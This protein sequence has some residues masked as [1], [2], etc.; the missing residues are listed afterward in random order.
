MFVRCTKPEVEDQIAKHFITNFQ[1]FGFGILSTSTEYNSLHG[2][3]CNLIRLWIWNLLALKKT[4]PDRVKYLCLNSFLKTI[5]SIYTWCPYGMYLISCLFFS[6]RFI[7]WWIDYFSPLPGNL[8]RL[9]VL[10]AL[11]KIYLRFWQDILSG[12]SPKLNGFRT[13]T[14][15]HS[16]TY[17]VAQKHFKFFKIWRTRTPFTVWKTLKQHAKSF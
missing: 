14:I 3:D 8:D 2:F 13:V 9:K 15:V 1:K 4:F 7:S 12:F 10:C 11:S 17:P 5:R 16:K 6:G